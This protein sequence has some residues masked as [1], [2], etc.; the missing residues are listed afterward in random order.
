MSLTIRNAGGRRRRSLKP[1]LPFR[2]P[3]NQLVRSLV[4]VCLFSNHVLRVNAV[5]HDNEILTPS[6]TAPPT[7]CIR[8]W[9]RSELWVAVSA[10]ARAAHWFNMGNKKCEN[11]E[12]SPKR[13]KLSG[14]YLGCPGSQRYETKT[15]VQRTFRATKPA[16]SKVGTCQGSRTTA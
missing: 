8:I 7:E 3:K 14:P 2:A 9:S 4:R 11:C 6:V 15:G 12:N 1:L 13:R 5:G 16:H 10:S